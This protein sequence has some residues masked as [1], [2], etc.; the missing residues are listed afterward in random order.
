MVAEHDQD[1]D[2]QHDVAAEMRGEDDAEHGQQARRATPT[3][4]H[5]LG[6]TR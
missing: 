5:G 2:E 1:A 4:G 6:S 3:I